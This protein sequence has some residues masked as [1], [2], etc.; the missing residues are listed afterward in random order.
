MA[1][2]KGGTEIS[3]LYVGANE[4]KEVYRGSDLIW[5]GGV[6]RTDPL[7]SDTIA[8]WTHESVGIGVLSWENQVTG[9]VDI[10]ADNGT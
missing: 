3:D 7:W 1:I 2:Y 5:S 8:L 4:V 9:K 6:Q 10:Q